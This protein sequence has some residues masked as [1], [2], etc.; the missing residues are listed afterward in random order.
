MRKL[1]HVLLP[2][3]FVLVLTVPA[4]V[5]GATETSHTERS[6]PAKSGGQVM[7]DASFHRVEVTARPGS[8]VDITVDLEISAS[9]KKAKQLL[10]DYEPRFETNGDKIVIR[11]I[12]KKSGWNW[13]TTRTNGLITVAMP[14]NMDLVVDNSSGSV[15]L[16][17]DFGD[18]K[19]SIDNSSGSV[20]GETA[21]TMLSVD[22]SSG[23]TDITVF[24]PLEQFHVDCSSGSVHLEGGAKEAR[25]DTSSG[26]VQ[27]GGLLGDAT[28]D[29]SSGSVELDWASISPDSEVRV[30][31]SSGG[32]KLS[33]PAGTTFRGDIDTSSGGIRSD[34]GCLEKERDHCEF[35]GGPGSVRLAVDTSSGGVSL[36]GR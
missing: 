14:P 4:L 35:D 5:F 29:T 12:R 10:A 18:A 8:T 3:L 30:D 9:A 28:V 13:G 21:M 20:K 27:L 16:K 6:F 1:T 22:N 19:A 34:F 23:K 31:T 32:V 7:V 36:A 33:F 11:S 2:A 15:L 26:R 17:G 25:V 24:R